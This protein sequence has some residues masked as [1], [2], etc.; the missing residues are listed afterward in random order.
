MGTTSPATVRAAAAEKR[1]VS[2]ARVT[3]PA[4][5]LHGLAASA[6]MVRV[7]RSWSPA[8]SRAA[9]SRMAAR[10]CVGSGSAIAS[11]AAAMASSRWCSSP[12]C[13]RPTSDPS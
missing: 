9:S 3:S 10:R 1:N 8:S 5:V 13:T 4:A 7:K 12:R 11:W 6:A 2:M